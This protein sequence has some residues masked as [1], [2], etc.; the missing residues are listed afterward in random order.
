MESLIKSQEPTISKTNKIIN[1]DCIKETSNIDKPSIESAS[2]SSIM[3]DCFADIARSFERL[4][5]QRSPA[6]KRK[7]MM[8]TPDQTPNQTPN[9]KRA[10]SIASGF[11]SP[12]QTPNRKQAPSFASNFA[13]PIPSLFFDD[14]S[15]SFVGEEAHK[16]MA[17]SILDHKNQLGTE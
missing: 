6:L 14:T 12:N 2:E 15:C 16:D 8:R 3:E 9:H 17:Y 1:E 13:S 11:A 4:S 7:R 5:I 10:P